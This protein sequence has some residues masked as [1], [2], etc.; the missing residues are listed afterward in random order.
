MPGGLVS[1]SE[2]WI[3]DKLEYSSIFQDMGS[4]K[5]Q[6]ADSI[7]LVEKNERARPHPC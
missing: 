4:Q 7:L 1:E 2:L 3:P 5:R 6:P